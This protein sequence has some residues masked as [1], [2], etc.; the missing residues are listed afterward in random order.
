MKDA[1]LTEAGQGAGG[2]VYDC[3]L[4]EAFNRVSSRARGF[5]ELDEDV[6]RADQGERFYRSAPRLEE[7]ARVPFE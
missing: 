1:R 6:M 7:A 2:G 3:V 4:A 5:E